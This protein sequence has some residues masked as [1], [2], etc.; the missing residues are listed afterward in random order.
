MRNM[1]NKRNSSQNQQKISVS[2]AD[3]IQCFETYVY[4][5][6]VSS[7][8]CLMIRCFQFTNENQN[9]TNV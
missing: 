6:H 4:F 5:S 2:T 8:F 3:V 7:G 9:K 1:Q